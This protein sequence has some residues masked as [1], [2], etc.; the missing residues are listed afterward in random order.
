MEPQDTTSISS[1]VYPISLKMYLPSTLESGKSLYDSPVE[2]QWKDNGTTPLNLVAYTT[3]IRKGP[4]PVTLHKLHSV[5]LCECVAIQKP[6]R[7]VITVQPR[8]SFPMVQ[9]PSQ[10]LS[11][12]HHVQESVPP[13]A[14]VRLT[15]WG[16]SGFHRVVGPARHKVPIPQQILRCCQEYEPQIYLE[17]A[18]AGLTTVGRY[19]N[20]R[21]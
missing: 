19:I 3:R 21:T 17:G 1:S 15:V 20:K 11:G 6:S 14:T 12:R 4:G 10:T 13:L 2:G 7:L 9:W 8:T 5:T 18:A 16:W